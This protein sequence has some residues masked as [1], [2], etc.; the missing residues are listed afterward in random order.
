MI[1]ISSFKIFNQCNVPFNDKDY[2][3]FYLKDH[4]DMGSIYT[5]DLEII[6]QL[7]SPVLENITPISCSNLNN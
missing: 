3:I 2:I 1:K 6:E 4:A 5:R 7:N